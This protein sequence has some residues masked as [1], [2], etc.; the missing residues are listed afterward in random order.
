MTRRHV[1]RVY[2]KA[3][4][5]NGT[6]FWSGK[7]AWLPPVPTKTGVFRNRVVV[8]PISQEVVPGK[9]S[10]SLAVSDDVTDLPGAQWPMRLA[11]VVPAEGYPAPVR[12][13]C[14]CKSKWQASAWRV[15]RE[16][17]AHLRFGPQGEQVAPLLESLRDMTDEQ[18]R[19]VAAAWGAPRRSA[20]STAAGE[21]TAVWESADATLWRIFQSAAGEAAAAVRE[22]AHS[23]AWEASWSS[24]ESAAEA[25]A[26]EAARYA[27][28]YAAWYA[29]AA[30]VVRD[31]I[32]RDH[33][34]TL[35][36]PLRKA[37]IVV[38]PDD[39]V[40]GAP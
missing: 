36:M 24:A 21:A 4:R 3:V 27:A 38:H 34:D 2:Y 12:C 31:L 23:S 16:V 39:P 22:S 28:Q 7:V 19:A 9:H 40:V 8:H 35:T 30:L 11:V 37:G 15:L 26:L 25:S 20:R 18:A 32:S 29:A 10:T 5:P 6:D 17:P 13:R 14:G 1:Y 33:Y